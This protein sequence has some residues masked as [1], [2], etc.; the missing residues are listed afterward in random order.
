MV[1]PRALHSLRRARWGSRTLA[2]IPGRGRSSTWAAIAHD[3]QRRHI[4]CDVVRKGLSLAK[5]A[6]DVINRE[7]RTSCSLVWYYSST[8][9]ATKITFQGK[10]YIHADFIHI[11]PLTLP[12]GEFSLCEWLLR[13]LNGRVDRRRSSSDAGGCGAYVCVLASLALLDALRLLVDVEHL[14]RGRRV[15]L[16]DPLSPR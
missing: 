15:E 3:G 16:K 6:S 5:V 7:V 4:L 10:S 12:A 8:P 1:G 13:R 2:R 11:S 14:L 9:Y